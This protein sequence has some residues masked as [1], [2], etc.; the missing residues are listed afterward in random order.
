MNVRKTNYNG[1]IGLRLLERILYTIVAC[2]I[3]ISI[4]M[5]VRFNVEDQVVNTNGKFFSTPVSQLLN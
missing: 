1:D 3:V 5:V 4:Y 2:S